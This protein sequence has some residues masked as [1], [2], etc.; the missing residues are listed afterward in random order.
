MK[1][2]EGASKLITEPVFLGFDAHANKVRL[3]LFFWSAVSLIILGF[4]LK[5]SVDSSLL[6]LKFEG[7]TNETVLSILLILL[8]YMFF[9]FLWL[10]NDA[11]REWKLRKSGYRE[12]FVN[13]KAVENSVVDQ[14]KDRQSSLLFYWNYRVLDSVSRLNPLIDEIASNLEE[15]NTEFN[16][17]DLNKITEPLEEIKR[18]ISCE[19]FGIPKSLEEFEKGF[20]FFSFSQNTRW[21]WLEFL[22]PIVLSL[23]AVVGLT[24]KLFL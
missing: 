21:F 24:C 22:L 15:G 9:H 5:V 8:I 20:K 16:K 4:N 12:L 14:T 18:L 7:L 10:S 11:Y 1:N 17:N 19:G 6:G 3:Q 13:P 23:S 2:T